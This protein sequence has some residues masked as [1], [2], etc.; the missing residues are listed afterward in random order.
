M[1][2][3]V[4]QPFG[5]V[6]FVDVRGPARVSERPE[7][8][9]QLVRDPSAAAR[10]QHGIVSIEPAFA[11][12]SGLVFLGEHLNAREWV[13]IA[14]VVVASVGATRHAPPDEVPV[15]PGATPTELVAA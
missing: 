1:K 7:I 5:D 10:V 8:E 3:V 12:V 13:A 15:D 6:G 14:C 4:H 2:S 9:N 11:A